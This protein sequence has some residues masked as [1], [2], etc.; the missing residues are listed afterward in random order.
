M[1]HSTNPLHFIIGAVRKKHRK[2]FIHHDLRMQHCL[3]FRPLPQGHIPL[4]PTRLL[5][6]TKV[7]DTTIPGSVSRSER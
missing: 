7:D 3:N 5:S 6:L 4:R 1:Q 2:Y